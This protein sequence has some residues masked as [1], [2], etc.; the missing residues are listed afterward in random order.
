MASKDEL[1]CVYAA[2]ILHDD[3]APISVENINAI[4]KAAN[5]T[6]APYWPSLFA[7]LL[8]NRNVDDLL[9]GGG[10]PAPVA[11]PEAPAHAGKK[12]EKKEEK[13]GKKEEKKEEAPAE[14]DG[15]ALGGLF[16]F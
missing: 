2:L 15:G 11:Q 12:E 5:V 7:K 10:A 4:L 6:V 8:E 13:K 16:D 3:K 9:M 14:D 1:A